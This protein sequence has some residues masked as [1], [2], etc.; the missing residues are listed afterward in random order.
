MLPVRPA[1]S[2]PVRA[3]HS[4]AVRRVENG[5]PGSTT[6][7][8]RTDATRKSLII[9]LTLLIVSAGTFVSLRRDTKK[10]VLGADPV[11]KADKPRNP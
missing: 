8:A 6:S 1:R 9:G 4:S 10:Q 11:A 3:L 5:V 7:P 2:A